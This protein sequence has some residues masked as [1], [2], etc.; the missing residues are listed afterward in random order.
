MKN[1]LNIFYCIENSANLKQETHIH[2]PTAGP[3]PHACAM[4][5]QEGSS[6]HRQLFCPYWGPPA[7][8]SRWVN[9]PASQ[10]PLTAEMSAKQSIKRQI[11]LLA[12]N[13]TAVLP[14]DGR[15]GWITSYQ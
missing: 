15:G 14:R 2:Q 8:Q 11:Q 9:E 12:G 7:W 1:R 4:Q 5:Y 3:V 13:R 6:S 10:K